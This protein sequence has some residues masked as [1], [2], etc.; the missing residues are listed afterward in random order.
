MCLVVCICMC[1]VY[2]CSN[3]NTNKREIEYYKVVKFEVSDTIK[4]SYVNTVRTSYTDKV[5][6]YS[7]D[8]VNSKGDTINEKFVSDEVIRFIPGDTIYYWFGKW[9]IK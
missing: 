7:F 9:S 5:Y 8:I 2:S 6:V 4:N 1:G 3:T